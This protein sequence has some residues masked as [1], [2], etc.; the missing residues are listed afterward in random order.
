MVLAA[1]GVLVS[2]MEFPHN[3]D[4]SKERRT[5]LSSQLASLV[6]T[7]YF[8]MSRDDYRVLSGHRES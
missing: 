8:G 5:P 1:R 3:Q 7:A 6:L 2:C 4:D